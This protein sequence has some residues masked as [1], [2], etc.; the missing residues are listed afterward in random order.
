MG[1]EPISLVSQTSALAFKL[2]SFSLLLRLKTIVLIT[3]YFF[4][5]VTIAFLTLV[6]VVFFLFKNSYKVFN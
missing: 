2:Y 3:H 6:I 5:F 1:L 4:G